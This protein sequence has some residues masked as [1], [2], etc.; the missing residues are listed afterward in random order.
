MQWVHVGMVEAALFTVIAAMIDRKHA[1][2][3]VA[4][5]ALEMAITEAE[6][7]YARKIGME[8]KNLPATEQHNAGMGS[9]NG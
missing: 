8:E 7:L 9:I 6:Y 2:A 5:A 1:A 3:F 4:G